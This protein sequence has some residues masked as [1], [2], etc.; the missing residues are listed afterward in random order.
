M[1][2]NEVIS[3]VQGPWFPKEVGVFVFVGCFF[4]CARLFS[5][6][7]RAK[8]PPPAPSGATPGTSFLCGGVQAQ[9]RRREH[10]HPGGR[11]G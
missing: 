10:D 2:Y 4:L 3:G 5:T 7:A 11:A 9:G 1:P 6:L 8:A